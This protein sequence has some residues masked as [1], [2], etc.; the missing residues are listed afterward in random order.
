VIKYFES[1][2]KGFGTSVLAG[3]AVANKIYRLIAS[4]I[5]GFSQGFGPVCGF[6][7]GARKYRRTKKSYYTTLVIGIC[8]TVVL[9]VTMF[10]FAENVVSIFNSSGNEMMNHI[11]S[12]KIRVLVYGKAP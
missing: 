3:I 2:A 7:W 5:L 12:L 10:I 11:G 6:C 1:V 4:V 9:G 8:G